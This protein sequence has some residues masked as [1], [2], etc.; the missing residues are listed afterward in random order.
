M[1]VEVVV[2]VLIMVVMA[3]FSVIEV[4]VVVVV[5]IMVMVIVV[6]MV[7]TAFEIG[8]LAK[9]YYDKGKK[10]FVFD[11]KYTEKLM[12]NLDGLRNQVAEMKQRRKE[13]YKTAEEAKN[14]GS[15]RGD[16]NQPCEHHL[17]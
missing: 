1:V 17:E 14:S 10:D 12:Y 11:R 4:V 6:V 3:F 2:V 8:A 5:M 9:V 13:A 7:I 15:R 16:R